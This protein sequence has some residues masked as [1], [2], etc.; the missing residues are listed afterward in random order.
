[1][2]IRNPTEH[3]PSAVWQGQMSFFGKRTSSDLNS[4]FFGASGNV[5]KVSLA[6]WHTIINYNKIQFT[7]FECV[8]FGGVPPLKN[9]FKKTPPKLKINPRKSAS[10]TLRQLMA[11]SWASKPWKELVEL[12]SATH[13][14][15]QERLWRGWEKVGC[16]G[17]WWFQAFGAKQVELLQYRCVVN[18]VICLYT[19]CLF[20]LRFFF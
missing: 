13:Q 11:A 5:P 4:L 7:T 18:I 12:V 20:L 1:M 6:W 3:F 14:Q 16:Y 19:S 17:V 10:K 9:H 8:L 2:F 15:V